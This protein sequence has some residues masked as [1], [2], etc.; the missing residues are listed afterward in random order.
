MKN[1]FIDFLQKTGVKIKIDKIDE[2]GYIS[3][4]VFCSILL[5]RSS[6]I[7]L[8]TRISLLFIEK[9]HSE[10]SATIDF[11]LPF[12]QQELNNFIQNEISTREDSFVEGLQVIWTDEELNEFR[13]L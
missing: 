3:N 13:G 10:Q 12:L 11:I 2:K 7:G 5:T 4:H 8:P 9:T 1:K 6:K